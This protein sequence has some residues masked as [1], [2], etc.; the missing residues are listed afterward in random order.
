M[1][2][3][4]FEVF[5]STVDGLVLAK[6]AADVGLRMANTGLEKFIVRDMISTMSEDLG[7]TNQDVLRV[8]AAYAL[9]TDKSFEIKVIGSRASATFTRNAKF[10][11]GDKEQDPM[12]EELSRRI[13]ELEAKLGELGKEKVRPKLSEEAVEK[14]LSKEGVPKWMEKLGAAL[15]QLFMNPFFFLLKT[16]VCLSFQAV[17]CPYYWEEGVP[18]PPHPHGMDGCCLRSYSLVSNTSQHILPQHCA[19]EPAMWQPAAPIQTDL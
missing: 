10:A 3:V 7:F 19:F 4:A 15:V 2:N 17:F 11:D 8:L 13:K 12:V 1:K 18:T 9:Y 16:I 14:L 6:T 5:L